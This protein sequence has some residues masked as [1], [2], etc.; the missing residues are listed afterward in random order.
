MYLL[1][2]NI[3][4][5][6]IIGIS[7]MVLL[8]ASF[9]IVF[10]NSQR[11]KLQY[12]KSLHAMYEEQQRILTQ[13]NVHLE[14]SVQERTFK[15]SEQKEELQK[16][17]AELRL[18]QLQL[19]QREKM[20]SMG[21]LTAGIAHEIQN[22]LNFINNF[23]EV[24]KELAEEMEKELVQGNQQ[25]ALDLSKNL[26]ENLDKIAHHGKRA[27]AIVK[28]ML[29]HSRGASG[30]KEP[31]GIN[32]M[33]D[34]YLRLTYHAVRA[35]NKGFNVVV[36]TDFDSKV[37][38]IN[39]YPQDLARVLVNLYNN[40]FYSMHEKKK[41]LKEAYEPVISI[42]TRKVAGNVVIR[43]KDNGMGIPQ[44]ILAKIFQ[45]FFTTKPSGEGTGLGLSLSYDIVTKGHRGELSVE[46]KEGE[47]AEFIVQLP[48]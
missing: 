21:E 28:G 1:D 48:A 45:P 14:K 9:L 26:K 17:L 43:V 34:E 12:H 36:Q 16:S 20:A 24:S 30:V 46:T 31:T 8:F 6:V 29:Q 2:L 7:A 19:V 18:T 3:E 15:L 32:D 4:Y 42:C 44:K 22:P 23:S 37:G 33:A 13:Q 41:L 40:A 38:N 11:R 10:I 5:R 47:G 25:E 35:K 27:E 39:V